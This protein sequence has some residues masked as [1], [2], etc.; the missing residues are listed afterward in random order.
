M[1]EAKL[2]E[3]LAERTFQGPIN[4]KVRLS[5]AVA[6]RTPYGTKL[7]KLRFFDPVMFF[8]NR[9]IWTER[10]NTEIVPNWRT[11]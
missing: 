5:A 8:E 2:Q 7:E 3:I 9:P 6:A 11:R 4:K 1:A 10:L